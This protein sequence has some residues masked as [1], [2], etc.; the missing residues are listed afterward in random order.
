MFPLLALLD[1]VVELSITYA[2]ATVLVMI[3]FK[4][5]FLS[6]SNIISKSGASTRHS[7]QIA[8]SFS[9]YQKQCPRCQFALHALSPSLLLLPRL[10]SEAVQQ[11]GCASRRR[12]GDAIGPVALLF[13]FFSSSGA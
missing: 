13:F 3:V 6:V 12:P 11:A 10:W 7:Q 9:K 8:S 1:T 4:T 2:E 5:S